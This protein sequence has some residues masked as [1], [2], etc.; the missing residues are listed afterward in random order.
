MPADTPETIPVPK[1]IVATDGSLLYQP[2]PPAS[3]NVVVRPAH[4][5]VVPDIAAGNEITVTLSV[6]VQPVGST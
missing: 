5:A 2:P 6:T 1:P 3:V 4:I